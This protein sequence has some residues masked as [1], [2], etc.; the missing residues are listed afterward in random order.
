M[1]E[2]TLQIYLKKWEKKGNRN[3]NLQPKVL[4][5]CEAT[6]GLKYRQLKKVW[7][8]PMN[9]ENWQFL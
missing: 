5:Q 1:N 3:E 4:R 2:K 6:R 9:L 8:Y 7:N